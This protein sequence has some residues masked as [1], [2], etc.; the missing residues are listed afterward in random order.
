MYEDRPA[1]V[2]K[3]I[4]HRSL[5]TWW[6]RSRKESS[7]PAPACLLDEQIQ[8]LLPDCLIYEVSHPPKGPIFV[9]K[10]QGKVA[11]R[12][13]GREVVDTAMVDHV[14]PE[15][16]SGVIEPYRMA[17]ERRR[18]VLTIRYC[19]D[20]DGA[21]L[22][23]ETLRFPLAD[24]DAPVRN[25]LVHYCLISTANRFDFFALKVIGNLPDNSVKAIISTI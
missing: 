5:L 15:I 10:F 3:S 18:P 23:I 1:S 22:A 13:F 16:F 8:D 11:F 14:N 7:C 6:Q 4:L 12:L 2:V 24:G 21:P 9:A 20:K 25:I 19:K 17:V